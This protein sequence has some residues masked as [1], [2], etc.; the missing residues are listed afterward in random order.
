MKDAVTKLSWKKSTGV[1]DMPDTFF[2]EILKEDIANGNEANMKWLSDKIMGVMNQQ[3]W[4]QY[5][6]SARPILLSK[7][8]ETS[9]SKK[10]VRILSVIP[11]VTK[12]I[13]RVILSR[14][15]FRLY[16]NDGLI[17]HCQQGFRPGAGT[18]DQLARFLAMGEKAL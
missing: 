11:A 7:N 10:N 5:L 4:P 14:M 3:H 12:L 6:F 8:G 9:T 13:E 1:D 15:E 2:H 17:P 16:G 18:S